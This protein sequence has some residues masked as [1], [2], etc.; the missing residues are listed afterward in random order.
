[1]NIQ[2]SPETGEEIIS[3]TREEYDDLIDGVRH[4]AT[5]R[6]IAAGCIETLTD[7]E[8]GDYLAAPTPIAFWRKR[9]GLTQQQLADAIGVS[10]PYIALLENGQREAMGS[11]YARLATALRVRADDLLPD[12]PDRPQ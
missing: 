8:V 4:E 9:R 12:F 11:V 7:A 1:M 2:R 10:Q 6:G 3:L 5:M